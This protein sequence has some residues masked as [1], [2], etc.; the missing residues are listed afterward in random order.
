M[1]GMHDLGGV[2]GMTSANSEY[3]GTVKCVFKAIDVFIPFELSAIYPLSLAHSP[4]HLHALYHI[5]LITQS[6]PHLIAIN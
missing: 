2:W 4:I 1:I 6:R 3:V 5:H